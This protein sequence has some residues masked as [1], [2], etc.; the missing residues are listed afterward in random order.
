[1]KKTPL[2]I[3][4]F[5][6][7]ILG[8]YG[9]NIDQRLS[10]SVWNAEWIT[11]PDDSGRE[12]EIIHFRKTISLTEK[13]VHFIVHVSADNRYRLFVNGEPVCF[14][15]ARGDIAHWYFETIDIGEFLN[16]GENTLA[17]VVWNFA[18]EKPVAQF[19]LETAFILQGNTAIEEIANTDTTWKVHKNE[20]YS[21]Y[22]VSHLSGPYYVVG[23]GEK[24]DGNLYPWEWELP[25]YDDSGWDYSKSIKKGSPLSQTEDSWVL[26]PRDIPFLEEKTIRFRKIA[27]TIGDPV[28]A[29]FITGN[30]PQVIPP[31]SKITL[32]FDQEEMTIAYPELIVSGGKNSLIT[33][34]YAEALSDG[35]NKVNRNQTGVLTVTGNHDSFKPDGGENRMFRP[36]WYRTYRYI[37]MEITTA[38]EALTLDDFTAVYTAY[39]FQQNS[40]FSSNN[41]LL[42]KIW[43]TG[44]RT[45]KLCA[46]ETYYD[47]PY[48]EQLQYIGD[49]R[50]QALIS[51]YMS[52][53]DRLVRK[54]LRLFEWSIND[55]G[56][57]QSRYPADENQI[58][59]T[60]SLF[61]ISMLYDY[62]L[63]RDDKE[64]LSPFTKSIEGILLWFKDKID[65]QT[66]M[67]GYVPYWNFVDWA[68]PWTWNSDLGMGGYPPGMLEGG[69]SI[70][71]LHFA[72][73]ID[74][75]VELF[76]YLGKK[77][78]IAEWQEIS[79][80]IKEATYNLCFHED[81]MLMA[82]DIAVTSYSQHAN[83]MAVISGC[84]PES[85][86]QKVMQNILEDESL[87]QAT[88]YFRFYLTRALEAT[89]MANKYIEL[90][91]PWEEMLDIGLTTFAEKPEPTRSDCHAWSGS[92]N[93]DFLATICGVKPSSPGFSSVQVKP[94]LGPLSFVSGTIPHPNG[95]ISV[96]LIKN[97]FGGYE[98]EVI[99]PKNVDGEFYHK[100]KT[101]P[102]HAGKN[103]IL[104]YTEI[105]SARI[106]SNENIINLT[107]STVIKDTLS[108][109]QFIVL[110]NDDDTI[111]AQSV[112]YTYAD[113]NHLS[114]SL[115][116]EILN[117]DK[118]LLSYIDS[119]NLTRIIPFSEIRVNNMLAGSAPLLTHAKTSGSGES[120]YIIFNKPM[121]SQSFQDINLSI[122]SDSPEVIN[123][124]DFSYADGDSSVV[125]L[126][127]DKKLWGEDIISASYTGNN[128][129]SLDNGVLGPFEG[130][131]IMNSL[132]MEPPEILS[133]AVMNRG[134]EIRIQ[135]SKEMRD[136]YN[137]ATN[138]EI[139]A[140]MNPVE[141]KQ[142]NTNG[143]MVIFWPYLPIRYSEEVLLSYHKG[144]FSSADGGLLQEINKLKVVNETAPIVYRI[145]GKIEVENYSNLSGAEISISTYKIND[146]D[147]TLLHP[148]NWISYSVNILAT[149]N[150]QADF[151]FYQ[152]DKPGEIIFQSAGI[153]E[154]TFD[155]VFIPANEAS[156]SW[157][158]LIDTVKLEAGIQ[159]LKLLIGKEV[160]RINLMNFR[161][162]SDPSVSSQPGK[163][164][165][166]C[167][168]LVFPNPAG[169]ELKVYWEKGF[170]MLTV[171]GMDGKILI[172][173]K[174]R[175]KQ[176]YSVLKMEASP[177]IY[178]LVLRNDNQ[179]ISSKIIKNR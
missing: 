163:I 9:S 176:E 25:D 157:T 42:D 160:N 52:G 116:Q 83:I 131:I 158:H 79:A 170:N 115:K 164:I 122:S 106:D 14:G 130:I 72:Y 31:N 173:K 24:V 75:A 22:S 54:A 34:T 126:L 74:Q 150:Y 134:Q 147:V 166:K 20:A 117:T 165:D 82:D 129:Q 177:G 125:E 35:G 68:I 171:T 40:S 93:Y 56:I 152:D 11:Y 58:I 60:Y 110:A 23:S 8:L 175:E 133:A 108:P 97:K 17:A 62:Y 151:I 7:Q 4:I 148:G 98:G 149:G 15:P 144:G 145:P 73:T 87:I 13:P 2:L 167:G 104:P 50:I 146:L 101:V 38:D 18:S 49:T 162:I 70:L 94:C 91:T 121:K 174:Y 84:L 120:V 168:C 16:S 124:T 112:E 28:N 179:M 53:D 5:L 137:F 37:E 90:L 65:E 46:F 10:D 3:F 103:K 161:K 78:S 109:E 99:L 26:I 100:E 113:S 135:F 107:F 119:N 128:I 132:E 12:Y 30:A 48:W 138:F 6:I 169:N 71:T 139:L 127:L 69:S 111:P 142:I 19:S 27:R 118:L 66:N 36:L 86:K 172:Q 80:K 64:F 85:Q 76:K 114:L 88:M 33:I 21:P 178:F 41:P 136:A 105:V 51:M 96:S 140:N 55:E 81:K 159:E 67:L 155:T 32:L 63:F 45:A 156:R 154:T 57:T 102:L 1:M 123:I 43:E 92:P 44:W 153:P 59:P 39:P 77:E 61:W 95:Q 143:N 89:G 141:I 29:D 47:C